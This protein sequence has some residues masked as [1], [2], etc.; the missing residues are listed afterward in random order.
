MVFGGFVCPFVAFWVDG[1]Y[2]IWDI[3]R[4]VMYLLHSDFTT[5]FWMCRW[6]SLGHPRRLIRYTHP[7]S[8]PLPIHPNSLKRIPPRPPRLPH[9]PPLNITLHIL[10]P[11]LL[12]G[13]RLPPRTPV[14]NNTR[15]RLLHE[16][17][18][19]EIRAVFAGAAGADFCASLDIRSE[20]ELG[21]MR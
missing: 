14:R 20:L 19:L 5:K 7:P 18:V 15:P 8:L 1:G 17:R 4:W 9:P 12:A 6:I 3:Y 13:N 11:I 10:T 21:S 16:L 2:G